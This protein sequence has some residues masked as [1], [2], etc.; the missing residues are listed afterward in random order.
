[1][2]FHSGGTSGD[3]AGTAM[4][5]A[6][7]HQPAI[8]ETVKTLTVATTT[9][10]DYLITKLPELASGRHNGGNSHGGHSAADAATRELYMVKI[11][12]QG[13]DGLVVEGMRELLHQK[14]ART[15]C[16]LHLAK[17]MMSLR[18]RAAPK[19]ACPFWEETRVL[20]SWNAVSS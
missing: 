4:K 15:D 12:T 2:E 10:D 13:F 20:H 3:Y 7:Q 14:K 16:S 11:D 1:V 8:E 17:A 5:A 18:Y 19:D 6:W 9:L